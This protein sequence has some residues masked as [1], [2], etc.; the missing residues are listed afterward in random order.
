MDKS[1]SLSDLKSRAA[2]P[3]AGSFSRLMIS[4]SEAWARQIEHCTRARTLTV[5]GLQSAC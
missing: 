5:H 4:V 2:L 1:F 3:A